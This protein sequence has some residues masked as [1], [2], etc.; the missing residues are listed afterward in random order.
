M[1]SNSWSKKILFLIVI[2]LFVTLTTSSYSK[3]EEIHWTMFTEGTGLMWADKQWKEIIIPDIERITGGRLKIDLL[4][5]GE[6]PYKLPDFLR[7]ISEGTADL[8]L[9]ALPTLSGTEPRI[10]IVNMPMFVPSYPGDLQKVY[11][12]IMDTVLI[13]VFT[14]WNCHEVLT[15]W[16]GA[17][18]FYFK[19]FWLEDFNSLKGK[20]IRTFSPELDDL[21]RLLNGTPVR[22]DVS[23]VYTAL[24]AGVADGFITGVS[25]G[26]NQK[27]FEVVKNMQA[28][29]ISDV[30]Q[31]VLVNNDSWNSLPVDIQD[32]LQEYFDSK[33]EWYEMGQTFQNGLDLL[34]SFPKFGLK[35]QPISEKL[36]EEIIEKSYEGIWKPWIKRCGEGGKEIFE[37]VSEI[38]KNE[39]FE[40][41]VYE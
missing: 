25:N 22:I 20:K 21:V 12:K 36:R 41:P 34:D 7:V 4:Y 11:H 9:I 13:D 24:Q 2:V 26:H 18:H 30:A 6:Y 28:T 33:R 29:F 17:Q 5:Y 37:D 39:G 3:E 10:T 38:L 35:V 31:A 15:T 16:M 1:M 40:V 23:E 32:I 14:K 8:V 19:D 27:Y